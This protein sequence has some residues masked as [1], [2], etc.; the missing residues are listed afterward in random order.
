MFN[1][2]QKVI[3]A[4]IMITAS[5]MAH[6]EINFKDV[7]NPQCVELISNVDNA[8]TLAHASK[9][10]LAINVNKESPVNTSDD[11]CSI[12]FEVYLKDKN[13]LAKLQHD[14]QEYMLK[15]ASAYLV[16]PK[17]HVIK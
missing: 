6:A 10:F 5:S 7:G 9:K 4:T 11:I 12:N 8:L 3:M 1:T 17:S 15:S 16:N 13:Q 14:F 2:L